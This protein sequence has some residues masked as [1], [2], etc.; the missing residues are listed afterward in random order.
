M[1]AIGID[2]GTTTICGVVLDGNTGE[3]LESKTVDNNSS[4]KSKEVYERIQDPG[5]ILSKVSKIVQEFIESFGALE[6]IG[7]TGQMHGILY[8]N[9]KDIITQANNV[10]VEMSG[11]KKDDLLG[12]SINIFQTSPRLIN[13]IGS[14]E[15]VENKEIR[16]NGKNKSYNCFLNLKHI[17]DQDESSSH[18]VL[19]FTKMDEIQKLAIQIN[20]D[21]QAFFTFDDIIGKTKILMDT[22]ELA[23]KA[24]EHGTRVVIEGESGTGKEMFAQ[25]IHNSSKRAKGPF[26]AVDCGDT[27]RAFGE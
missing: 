13:I 17:S 12:K 2:I 14:L 21:N 4:L 10:M 23:K 6:S 25:A 22:I 15:N 20:G 8:V 18:R 5:L 27:K 3:V 24:A 16:I 9:S 26:V 1:Q 7:I 19:V 11:L